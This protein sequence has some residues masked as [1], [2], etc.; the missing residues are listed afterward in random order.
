MTTPQPV[1]L[2]A[3]PPKYRTVPEPSLKMP[4]CIPFIV[5]NEFAERFSFYG[6]GAILVVFMTQYM[7]HADG[8][9]DFLSKHDA[10][11]W[12]HNFNSFVYFTPIFGAL[13]ADIFWGKYHTIL[14]V[15]LLYC[16]GH[17]VLAMGE[18]RGTLLLGLTL[19]GIGAGG[20]K[21]CVSANVGDQF[22]QSNEHLLSKV[23]NWFYFSINLGAFLSM[24]ITPILLDKWGSRVAFGVPGIVMAIAVIIF[25][26]GRK[27]YVHAP[28]LGWKK[29]KENFTGTNLKILIR[30]VIFF[31][32]VAPFYAL[33]YEGERLVGGAGAIS[34][35]RFAFSGNTPAAKPGAI[36]QRRF[37][38]GFHPAFCVWGVSGGG[39][40]CKAD[41]PAQ[42]WRG[43]VN[44]DP[45][46]HDCRAYRNGKFCRQ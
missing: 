4:R 21:P 13:I 17:G 41:T 10:N 37:D 39:A 18:T 31:M 20:I 40:F 2:A 9:S 16:V 7:K 38:S 43:T 32:F 1:E 5:A 36:G 30:L 45:R 19:I 33:Y 22:S 34:G 24:M 42:N 26:L 27:K 11:I 8:T 3:T 15:S 29:V 23:Y 46:L 28:P 25:W 6:M 35:P 14:W 44:V 12:S